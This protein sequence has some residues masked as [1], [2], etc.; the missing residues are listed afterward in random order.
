M[1][2]PL[3]RMP[4]KIEAMAARLGASP[5]GVIDNGDFRF[6]TFATKLPH[7]FSLEMHVVVTLM[8]FD[9]ADL[10]ELVAPN[11]G[12]WFLE[13]PF[14]LSFQSRH[15]WPM[16]QQVYRGADL[17]QALH[18]WEGMGQ[19][20]FLLPGA[21]SM[22]SGTASGLTGVMELGADMPLAL[23][24]ALE[25]AERRGIRLRSIRLLDLSPFARRGVLVGAQGSERA[26]WALHAAYAAVMP[27]AAEGELPTP[28]QWLEFGGLRAGRP[29]SLMF[30]L[31]LRG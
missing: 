22:A 28:I 30:Q 29:D 19:V 14:A 6:V 9:A 7:V 2:K 24:I 21:R 5:V 23:A 31:P 20:L 4:P 25:D 12:A 1:S 13:H 17:A 26:M 15:P 27:V 10:L 8:A 16:R 3:K 18:A 11:G